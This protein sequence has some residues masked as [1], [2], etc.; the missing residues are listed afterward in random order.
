M[1]ETNKPMRP[2]ERRNMGRKFLF[3]GLFLIPLALFPLKLWAQGEEAAP[4]QQEKAAPVAGKEVVEARELQ[5]EVSAPETKAPVPGADLEQTLK[6]LGA[7]VTETEIRM[8]LS[9]DILFDTNRYGVRPDAREALGK[10]AVVIRAYPEKSV[11]VEGH[12]DFEG[13]QEYNKRLSVKRAESVRRWLR[14]KEGLTGTGFQIKGW[15][16]VRPRASNRTAEGRQKNRRVEI[17]IL[18]GE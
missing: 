17:T 9:G 3:C 15:G 12:T 10:V 7:R 2:H 5:A 6:E 4:L 13:S 18:K 16:K 8:D 1:N 14:E 11:R